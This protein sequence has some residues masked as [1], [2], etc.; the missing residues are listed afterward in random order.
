LDHLPEE[1]SGGQKKRVALAMALMGDPALL[2][3]DEPFSA[4]DNPLKLRMRECLAG[5]M[6][7]LPIPV[8]LVTHDIVEAISMGDAMHVFSAGRVI[9]SGAPE[10]ILKKPASPEVATL[11]E[12][13]SLPAWF[14]GGT[15]TRSPE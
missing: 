15:K 14:Q 12:I 10:E 1:I 5:V 3:L 8:L 2:L 4:L 11:M 6:K 7:H 9:Q 13:P